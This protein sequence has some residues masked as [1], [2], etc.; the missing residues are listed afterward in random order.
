MTCLRVAYLPA[1]ETW[2]A[3][4]IAVHV[5]P[6]AST[7]ALQEHTNQRPVWYNGSA[8]AIVPSR[9]M[10]DR[11]PRPG[12]ASTCAGAGPTGRGRFARVG[13]GQPSAATNEIDESTDERDERMG[14]DDK[15]DA[16]ADELKGKAKETVGR[17]TDDEELEN[18]GEGDQAK[19][20]LKQAGE[21]V[22]D[23][24]KD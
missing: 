15:I 20:N 7:I 13:G 21:K 16:K 2:S 8:D 17:V 22:K 19:G 10:G 5:N 9:R 3:S 1:V 4:G 23:I 18:E 12:G 11:S 6:L 24:F 14:N